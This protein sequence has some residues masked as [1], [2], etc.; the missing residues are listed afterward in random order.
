MW[1]LLPLSSAPVE[2]Y[3]LIHTRISFNLF[4][5]S[6]Q[7]FLQHLKLPP[8][9]GENF[10]NP[11]LYQVFMQF[12]VHIGFGVVLGILNAVLYNSESGMML[13]C[14]LLLM[15]MT[16]MDNFITRRGLHFDVRPF[17]ALDS[18]WISQLWVEGSLQK[19]FL[20]KIR[21]HLS[22][23]FVCCS[24][25]LLSRYEIVRVYGIIKTSLPSLLLVSTNC[26]VHFILTDFFIRSF[27]SQNVNWN[28]FSE[29]DI[30][31]SLIPEEIAVNVSSLVT[32]LQHDEYVSNQEVTAKVSKILKAKATPSFSSSIFQVALLK[33]S[34]SNKV[35]PMLALYILRY[36]A[37]HI[38]ALA[39]HL[40]EI[41]KPPTP[42]PQLP[43]S[44]INYLHFSIESLSRLL[45]S[46]QRHSRPFLLLP[47]LL[48]TL[49]NLQKGILSHGKMH[50]KDDVRR[51]IA[52]CAPRLGML[53]MK[54][55]E[56]ALELEE[57]R[58]T[59]EVR[60]GREV[61][62]WIDGLK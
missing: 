8:K 62:L 32:D 20:M 7:Y 1:G 45:S 22:I 27:L 57:M 26:S 29:R 2:C 59:E 51:G 12:I 49:R 52:L 42:V 40:L 18:Q 5:P 48:S 41:S 24:F 43:V 6:V 3:T 38:G 36:Q 33:S 28:Q 17:A 61:E 44:T 50:S 23:L 58:R 39:S 25:Y 31:K 21:R 46:Q 10:L 54:L 53:L 47:V 13:M 60:V 11:T 16:W 15:S 30:F 35:E 19:D 55:E 34:P 9:S 56:V 14:T 37:A 4:F